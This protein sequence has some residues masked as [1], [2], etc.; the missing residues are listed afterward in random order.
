L[1]RLVKCCVCQKRETERPLVCPPC[2]RGLADN[3]RA[4]V[5]A[6]AMLV[7]GEVLDGANDPVSQTLPAGTVRSES[8]GA[9]V[10]GSREAP[11]PVN[12]DVVDLMLPAGPGAIYDPLG[13]LAA[14]QTGLIPVATMLDQWVRDWRDARGQDEHLPVPTVVILA[15]WLYNRLDWACDE[16]TA[17]DEFAAE[18]RDTLRACNRVAGNIPARPEVLI[19]VPCATPRCD[20][21]LMHD[22]TDPRYWAECGLCRRLWTE[23]EYRS[24][25]KLVAAQTRP[26]A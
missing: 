2:R 11:V 14:M 6:Y 1:E 3:L 16:F 7:V 22:S 20:G 4:L 26:A 19:G 21:I 25:T 10:T 13:D 5:D 18:V 9:P 8:R 17:V 23:E 12:L 15:G 24:W